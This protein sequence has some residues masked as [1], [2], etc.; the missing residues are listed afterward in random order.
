MGSESDP[1][2]IPV[3]NAITIRV[4]SESIRVGS[5]SDPVPIRVESDSD[6][7]PASESELAKYRAVPVNASVQQAMIGIVEALNPK[8]PTMFRAVLPKGAELVRAIGTDGFRGFSRTDGKTAHAVLKPVAAGGAVAVRPR[9]SGPRRP[10]IE[11]DRWLCL[12]LRASHSR[13]RRS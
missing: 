8:Q 3:R 13:R 7:A 9:L 6:Q 10:G 1:T 12:R 2:R 11:L 5:D 4:G